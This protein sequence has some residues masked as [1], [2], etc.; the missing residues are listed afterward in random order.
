VAGCLALAL[1]LGACASDIDLPDVT[2]PDIT[3]P[4]ITPP[5]ITLPTITPP[6]ITLPTLPTLPGGGDDEPTDEPTGEPTDEPTGEPTDE[7][8]GEPTD[9]PTD[10]GTA[11]P[12]TTVTVTSTPPPSGTPST[13]TP[14]TPEPDTTD[15]T[16]APE[17]PGDEAEDAGIPWWVWLLAALVLLALLTWFVVRRAAAARARRAWAE[18]VHVAVERLTVPLDVLRRPATLVPAEQAAVRRAVAEVRDLSVTFSELAQVAPDQALGLE[19]AGAADVLRALATAAEIENEG[20]ASGRIVSFE[21][22]QDA[23]ARR[24]AAL[25]DVDATLARLTG[26]LG[27]YR[28]GD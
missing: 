16:G 5:D 13:D 25:G 26:R 20:L 28:P 7:P 3:L 4:D 10:T 17:A 21:E 27:D 23:E 2:V 19:A 24:L 1:T 18:R 14:T 15:A 11:A 9:E 12:T 8:T 6:D 22:R